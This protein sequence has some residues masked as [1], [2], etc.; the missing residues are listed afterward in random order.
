MERDEVCGPE[1]FI[2]PGV[3]HT[4]PAVNFEPQALPPTSH[5]TNAHAN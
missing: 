2:Y 1:L 4:T 5:L 3:Y